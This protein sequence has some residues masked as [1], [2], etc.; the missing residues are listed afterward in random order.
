[1]LELEHLPFASLRLCVTSRTCGGQDLAR[2]GAESR[3]Q[4]LTYLRLMDLRLGLLM[5]FG[6]AM[7]R[8]GVKRVIN[9]RSDRARLDVVVSSG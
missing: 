1:M 9:G 5:N 2:G 6:G 8:E 4:L 3:K 7:F